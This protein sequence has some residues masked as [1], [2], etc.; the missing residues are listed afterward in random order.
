MSGVD[1]I[2]RLRE[3]LTSHGGECDAAM[4]TS[5]A[6]HADGEVLLALLDVAGND[7]IEQG[8]PALEKTLGLGLL[9]YE[10]G[11]LAIETRLGTQLLVVVRIGKEAY[12][13]DDIG[14]DGRAVF[15]TEGVDRDCLLYTS[16]SPRD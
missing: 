3:V 11:D 6:A 8:V 12:V 9:E 5:R 2:A 1:V 16:P 15:E 14:I 7:L 4:L 10:L 13:D